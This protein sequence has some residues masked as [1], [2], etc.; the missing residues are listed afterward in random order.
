MAMHRILC[1]ITQGEMGGAQRFV[2]QLAENLDSNQFSIHVIWGKHTGDGIAHLLPPHTTWST[3]KHLVRNPS[4]IND[5]LAIGE[6]SNQFC[7]RK[8]D[9]ILLISSKAGF[10]GSLA[11]RRVRSA[12]PNTKVIYRIGGWTFNDPWH[13]WQ[14]HMYRWMEKFSARLKD[15]IVVNSRHDLLRAEELGICPRQKLVCIHNGIDPFLSLPSSQDARGELETRLG[16]SFDNSPVVGTIAN[17]YPAKDLGVFIRAAARMTNNVQF[18]IIGIGPLHR[19]L[20]ALAI[21]CGLQKRFHFTGS[22]SKAWE[23]LPA[24]NAFALS[25]KKEGFPWALLEAMTARLAVVAT[26]VGAVPEMIENGISG[27]IVPP[28]NPS[29][30]ADALGLIIRDPIRSQKLGIAAHQRVL[31]QFSVQQMVGRYTKLFLE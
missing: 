5:L 29:A 3:I 22:I 13:P 12:L 19:E 27:L 24:F 6:L 17:F 16:V 23:F 9:S 7:T 30:L 1:V 18:V 31:E 20:N 10:V 26:S 14:G 21:Q 25:S 15:V 11:A 8:P 4:P 2:G 28:E